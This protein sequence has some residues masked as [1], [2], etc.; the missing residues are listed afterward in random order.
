[1]DIAVQMYGHWE[2]TMLIAAANGLSASDVPEVG[3]RLQI[4]SAVYHVPTR[5]Y[6]MARAVS[7]AT[8]ITP[9]IPSRN[10]SV[11]SS[12]EFA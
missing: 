3:K 7:P 1:M 2:G 10:F 8:A 9:I 4:P 11:H 6:L 12:D 5:D